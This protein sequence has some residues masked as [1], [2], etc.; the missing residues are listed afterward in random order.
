MKN[1]KLTIKDS[2]LAFFIGFLLCQLGVVVVSFAATIVCSIL[3]IPPEYITPFFNTAV[4]YLLCA[5]AMDIV[6]VLV[7]M[8][9]NK[10]K[11][12]KIIDKPTIKKSLIYILI[13][14]IAYFTSAPIV[15]CVDSL[16]KQIGIPLNTIPYNLT[17]GNYFISLISLVLLPAICEEL[18]FRGIIF[19][20]LK[21]HG[22][23]FSITLTSL[24]FAIF[25]MS[26]DQLIYPI[27]MGLLLSIVMYKENNLFYCFIIHFVNNFTSLTL[28]YFKIS[29]TFSHW[30]FVLFA[31][32]LAIVFLSLIV[33]AI[34][35][36]PN[37]QKEVINHNHKFYLI[38]CLL[39]MIIMWLIIN[40]S[41]Y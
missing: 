14:V 18:L 9:F 33:L 13:A 37:Q 38:I 16:L 34:A 27:F 28:A 10:H 23:V 31:I 3:S 32:I 36:Q 15:V 19:K 17:R 29:L 30:T 4:G 26:I 12:N 24:M 39:A 6:M 2:S 40:I 20:G 1:T 35:K 25:H 21:N 5:L 11:S 7:F 8:F 41:I 22:K